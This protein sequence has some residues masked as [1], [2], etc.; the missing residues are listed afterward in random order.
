MAEFKI[1]ANNRVSFA[2]K[3]GS[4]KT[5][6]AGFL[7]KKI[8]RKVVIDPKNSPAIDEWNL[9]PYDKDTLKLLGNPEEHASLRVIEPPGGYD[10]DGFPNWDPIFELA[11]DLAPLTIYLDEM[12]S[13]AKNG[14][15]SYPLRRLYTQGR[16]HGIGVWASTQRP[17]KVPKEMFTEAEW[18]LVFMLR[19]AKD[20]KEIADD[21]GYDALEE[22]V[23]DEHGFYV[24]Y[25]TWAEPVYY[26]ILDVKEPFEPQ[27]PPI[28]QNPYR[29]AIPKSERVV[30]YA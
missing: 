5:F 4:G 27:A 2:G 17:M 29:L 18:G 22:P 16:E 8:R 11:W 15:L 7:L 1:Y 10:K 26:P 6:A 23:R 19:R 9:L 24:F 14:Q 21:T 13:T 12:Y 28:S 25:E 30:R 20:R 3:T